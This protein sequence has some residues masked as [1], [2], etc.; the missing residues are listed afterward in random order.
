[1]MADGCMQHSA[2]LKKHQA[3]EANRVLYD[4]LS[5]GKHGVQE[6]DAIQREVSYLSPCL[7]YGCLC[8]C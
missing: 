2:G 4:V 1:M 5:R 6:S 8:Q 7:W 3:R